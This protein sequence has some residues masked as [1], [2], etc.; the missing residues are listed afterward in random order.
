LLNCPE[1][2]LCTAHAR[3][4]VLALGKKANWS[5]PIYYLLRAFV[6]ILF[7]VQAPSCAQQGVR[8]TGREEMCRCAQGRSAGRLGEFYILQM[9]FPFVPLG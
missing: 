6:L 3:R 4:L 7:D 9:F 8:R 5:C 2:Q 1:Q